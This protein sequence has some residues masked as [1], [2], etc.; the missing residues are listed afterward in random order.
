MKQLFILV[1]TALLV[2]SCCTTKNFPS[3]QSEPSLE[4]V[5]T[6][7]QQEYTTAMNTLKK[8]GITG[9]RITEAEISLKVSKQVS[10]NGEIKVLIF[11]PSKSWSRTNT[12][13]IT[14]KLSEK[15]SAAGGAAF[16]KDK[17]RLSDIIVS[18][19]KNF[20]D[21]NATVGKLVKD[22]FT[23]ELAF[24]IENVNGAGLSF[25]VIGLSVDAGVEKT[26]T[27]EHGMSLTFKIVK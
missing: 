5:V 1:A 14:Y 22:E 15:E 16:N 13:T 25:E 24:E 17:R 18:A 11:K 26:T 7:L 3:N 23:I 12:T 19:A 21:L 9:V 4:E 20:N 2:T 10:A 8:D 6:A 27:V